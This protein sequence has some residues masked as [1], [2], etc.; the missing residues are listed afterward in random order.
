MAL[1]DS[2]ALDNA[3]ILIM[4]IDRHCLRFKLVHIAY[5]LGIKIP[6]TCLYNVHHL[7][8]FS[9]DS[10]IALIN[11]FKSFKVVDHYHFNPPLKAM[12][13]PGSY[14]TPLMKP[15]VYSIFYVTFLIRKHQFLQTIV[16]QKAYSLSHLET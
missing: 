16:F 3:L 6:V 8:H 12:D 13:Y 9:S 4:T 15:V 14:L 10:L 7:N 1:I 2:L 11:K 5:L